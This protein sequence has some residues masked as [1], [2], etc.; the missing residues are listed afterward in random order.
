MHD[1]ARFVSWRNP[2][3]WIQRCLPTSRR[4]LLERALHRLTLDD[5]REVLI[6]GAGHDPYRSLFSGAER[7]VRFDIECVPGITDVIGD[8]MNMPFDDESFDC[9][10]A[11]ECMEHVSDPFRFVN[12]LT[13]VLRPGGLVVLTVPFL[14][15][16]HG[17]PFDF[18][19]PTRHCLSRLFESY[20][21]VVVT[22]LGHRIHVISDLITTAFARY[23]FL[24]PLRVFNHLLA[25]LPGSIRAGS[26]VTTAPT[27]FMV[28]AQK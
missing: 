13:R 10:V 15:H 22:S 6:V 9:V 21:T 20:E 3:H 14:F 12:Q 28:A 2:R 11:T 24:I 23:R 18:W 17:D 27:G 19:R 16:Q 4:L 8:A 1:P 26:D 5:R 7:Y 25:R